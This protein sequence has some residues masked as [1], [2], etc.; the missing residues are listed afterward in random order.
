M[1]NPNPENQFKPGQS[2]NLKGRPKREWTVAGL[3]EEAMEAEDDTGVSYKK[4]VYDKL[5]SM[6][7]AGDIQAVKEVNQRLDGMPKQTID[8]TVKIPEPIYGGKSKE[9]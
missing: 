4:I 7:K 8:A 2:G 3:I 5:V 9:E 6:A 1:S